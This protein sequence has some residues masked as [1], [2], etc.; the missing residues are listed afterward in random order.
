M[1]LRD[2]F[3]PESVY[4]GKEIQSY[5]TVRGESW[6][7]HAQGRPQLMLREVPQK[8]LDTL[9]QHYSGHLFRPG[10][11]WPHMMCSGINT[12]VFS[13]KQTAQIIVATL[14]T[15]SSFA[16][17][18]QSNVRKER[19]GWEDLR[20]DFEEILAQLDTECAKTIYRPLLVSEHKEFRLYGIKLLSL[21]TAREASVHGALRPSRGTVTQPSN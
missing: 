1:W 10:E 6:T 20:E 7:Q 16:A 2:R 19:L 14:L 3:A 18:G 17:T 9:I 5:E 8:D 21:C 12:G 13:P 4:Q 11:S 15:C